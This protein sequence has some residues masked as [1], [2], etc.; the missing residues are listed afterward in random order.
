MSHFS[1]LI[2]IWRAWVQKLHPACFAMVMATGIVA[3]SCQLLGMSWFGIGLTWLNVAVFL[4]LWLM[5]L[6]RIL[7][8]G[9][10]VLADLMDH[11]RG[12]G[13]F[14]T[15]AG[16]CVLGSQFILIVEH[17]P[18]AMLLWLLA[19]VLW[20]SLTYAIF[21]AYT[22]KEKKP[23]LAG[24][25]N[26]G[27]LVAVVATQAVSNLGVLLLPQFGAYRPLILF[28]CLSLWL[29]GIMLYIWLIVLIFYRYMFFPFSPC[30]LAPTYWI[31]MGA[32]AIS[33]LAGTA[34]IL[35]GGDFGLVRELAPFIE[36][37]TILCW[38]TATWW[39]PM[40][41]VL[42]VWRC[43]YERR[44]PAYDPLYWGAV[45][46]LGMYTAC[47]LR[48][49]EVTHQPFLAQIARWFIYVA[50]TAWLLTFIGFLHGVSRRL[51]G[52]TRERPGEDT[53]RKDRG[54]W[55]AGSP[56]PC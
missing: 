29:F 33:T 47:T 5:T 46:P 51:V 2:G 7:L 34:L 1:N 10:E 45:F 55:A 9:R 38:A 8:C 13:L 39:I 20:V 22:V 31:N 6:S 19:V 44:K 18:I 48:L 52:L 16:T 32:M 43:F 27:W 15:I 42:G 26:G 54:P 56:R 37:C 30:D 53:L 3:I 49:F 28:A 41:V 35:R 4:V 21:T 36:G 50:L 24:G 25:I 12:V 23:S 11:S 17:Y 14:T 40:L